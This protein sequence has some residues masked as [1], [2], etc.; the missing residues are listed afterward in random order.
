MRPIGVA[1]IVYGNESSIPMRAL[2]AREDGFAHIDPL[3]TIDPATLALPIGCPT[4]FPKPVPGW[5]S[6]TAVLREAKLEA[7]VISARSSQWQTAVGN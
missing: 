7:M 5:C 4:A 6:F 3:V 2:L 1:D